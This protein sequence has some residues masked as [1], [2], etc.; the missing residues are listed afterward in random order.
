VVLALA[1]HAWIYSTRPFAP[2]PEPGF[3]MFSLPAALTIFAGIVLGAFA[4]IALWSATFA[5][6]LPVRLQTLIFRHSAPRTSSF[7]HWGL[8]LL[9]ALPW[10]RV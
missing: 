5:V 1:P 10:N 8:S 7:K 4:G 2:F 6:V 9:T 3:F